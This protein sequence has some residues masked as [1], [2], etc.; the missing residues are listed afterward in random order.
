MWIIWSCAEHWAGNPN[1]SYGWAVPLL[2]AGFALRRYVRIDSADLSPTDPKMSIFWQLALAVVIA[3]VVFV[4]E[5]ARVE[6]WHPEIVLWSIC[7][8]GVGFT[9][10]AFYFRGGRVLARA[11]LFPVVFFLTA[12]PWPPRFEQP[13]TTLLIRW[14]AAATT[15]LLHWTGIEAQSSGGAIALRS[16]LVG[17]SEACSGVRSLQAGIMFGLAMGEWFLLRPA[18]RVFL[19]ILAVV[20]AL[21]T[22]LIRTLLLSLQAE[23][24]GIESLDRVHDLIG[25][26]MI[27]ALIL[28]IWIAGRL[29]APPMRAPVSLSKIPDQVGQFLRG[30]IAPSALVFRAVALSFLIGIVC[31]RCLYAK[32]AAEDRTQTTPFF[33]TKI[34]NSNQLQQLP[35]E[36]RNELRPTSAEYIRRQSDDLPRGSADCFHFFWKPSAWNRFALVH[37]PDICMPGIGWNEVAKPQP[38]DV[39]MDGHSIRC[40]GFRFQRGNFYA[41]ELWGV[42]RNGEPVPLDYDPA[43]V[44]GAALPPPSLHLEGKRRSATEIVAC[45]LIAEGNAP[46]KEKAV[47]LLQSVFQYKG[48]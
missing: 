6:M 14:V 35:R 43:Q 36:I 8:L 32:R 10:V 21:A 25:N 17:I 30:L 23:R 31:A 19:L 22:N 1:Y 48:E 37:R 12:V 42:W 3:V 7:L 34:D 11:E 47:A 15:E 9:I 28:G 24:H 38:L 16:G 26:V 18:R 39:A 2:A 13:I 29:L 40:Y 41:L 4:L 5:Y 27:T 44:F 20:L 46:S 33:A 45:T